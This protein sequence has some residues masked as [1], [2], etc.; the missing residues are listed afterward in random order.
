LADPP[1]LCRLKEAVEWR[2]ACTGLSVVIRWRRSVE[3]W[4]CA[5]ALGR[6]LDV[7]EVVESVQRRIDVPGDAAP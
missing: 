2:T 1:E 3:S 4:N 7:V 5:T 6:T